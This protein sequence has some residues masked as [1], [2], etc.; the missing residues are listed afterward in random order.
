MLAALPD[1]AP[2][3]GLDEVSGQRGWARDWVP[4]GRW[5]RPTGEGGRWTPVV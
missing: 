2:V 4:E 1:H 3:E 5:Q